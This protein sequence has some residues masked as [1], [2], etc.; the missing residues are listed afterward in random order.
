MWP[1][2]RHKNHSILIYQIVGTTCWH[3]QSSITVLYWKLK[4]IYLQL[5]WCNPMLALCALCQYLW[6]LLSF[7]ELFYRALFFW[8]PVSIP[9]PQ[10]FLLPPPWSSLSSDGRDLMEISPLELCIPGSVSLKCLAVGL[11]VCP[12]CCKRKQLCRWLNKTLTM[13]PAE[14][15]WESF[16]RYIFFLFLKRFIYFMYMST[17]YLSSDTPDE[18]IRSHYRCLWATM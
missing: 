7:A 18:D 9:S 3:I 6:V 8:C 5:T 1:K 4:Y 2:T 10:F 12:I 17:M 11:C 14:Y 16:Y 13:T 15:Q